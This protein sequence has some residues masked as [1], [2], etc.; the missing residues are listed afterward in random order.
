MKVTIEL[1]EEQED[2]VTIKS[3]KQALKDLGPGKNGL[4]FKGDAELAK[5]LKLL[6]KHY[7]RNN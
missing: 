6:I 1:S 4:Y 5:A 7:S 2:A 3:L